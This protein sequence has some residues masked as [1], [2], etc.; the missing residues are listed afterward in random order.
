MSAALTSSGQKKGRDHLLSI[1]LVRG[2]LMLRG[3]TI[4][5]WAVSHGFNHTAVH[6]A[7]AG[8]RIGPKHR[9]MVEL[10]R[11]DCGL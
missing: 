7:M 4:K 10:L 5:S 8:R 2:H 3:L 11:K 6:H 9:Q 1:N